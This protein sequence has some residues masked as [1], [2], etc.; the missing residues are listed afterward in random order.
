L[1]PA[2]VVRKGQAVQAYRS[3]LPLLHGLMDSFVRA[4]ELYAR[5]VNRT[6]PIVTR[7]DPLNPS[8]WTDANGHS[9]A[10]AE[11]DPVGDFFVRS[12]IP[13]ADLVAAYLARDT[14]DN[15]WVCS[16]ARDDVSTGLTYRLRLKALD[17]GG[18]LSYAARTGQVQ[19][20]W[21]K[22]ISSGV[23]TCAQVSLAELG[24]PWAVFVGTDVEG[25]GR[26]MDQTGWRLVSISPAP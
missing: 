11:G 15:L 9:I 22:A 24:N 8:T 3:Q 7:G 23:Y 19:S 18:V 10:P 25:G 4:N 12:A 16:Q 26:L 13:G 2:E 17:G 1:T 14:S 20:G 21:K 6:L 5:V